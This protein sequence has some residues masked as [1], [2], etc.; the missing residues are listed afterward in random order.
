MTL[1]FS[2]NKISDTAKQAAKIKLGLSDEG[3]PC[4]LAS[5]LTDA[6]QAEPKQ[7]RVL[8]EPQVDAIVK[9]N[10]RVHRLEL[11]NLRQKQGEHVTEYVTC[12]RDKAAKCSFL[13][14]ELNKRLTCPSLQ[15]QVVT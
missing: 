15:G 2:D 4:V 13:D 7:I 6:E 8:L 1:F 14:D 5:G 10:F 11:S 3:M 12:I 9:I